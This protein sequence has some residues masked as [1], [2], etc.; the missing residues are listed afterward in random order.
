MD[1]AVKSDETVSIP[2]DQNLLRPNQIQMLEKDIAG[3]EA[4]M[5]NPAIQ[6]KGKV[7]KRLDGLK[8]QLQTQRPMEVKGAAKD[9]VSARVKELIDDVRSGMLTGEEMRKAPAGAPDYLLKWEKRNAKKITE[10]KNGLL[11]LGMSGGDYSG[12]ETDIANLEKFRPS[13]AEDRYRTDAETRGH[14]AMSPLAKFNW[15]LGEPTAD[16]ALKQA[17][18]HAEQQAEAQV[19]PAPPTK[20]KRV[21]SD[22]HRAKLRENLAKAR[23]RIEVEK[24]A[25]LVATE[26][27]VEEPK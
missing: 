26:A 16:T 17:E 4:D 15:P 2:T 5:S 10:L 22:E 3:L 8:R 7:R 21:I 20:Q 18:R 12:F 19:E 9:R 24:Q 14:L 13:G 27:P 6:M 25:T 11:M 23:A 1:I